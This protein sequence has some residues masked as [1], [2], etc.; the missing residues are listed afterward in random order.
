MIK[1]NFLLVEQL[2][3][4]RARFDFTQGALD[5]RH[6][7]KFV[8]A[9]FAATREVKSLRSPIL[10]GRRPSPIPPI[11]FTKRRPCAAPP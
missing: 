10:T 8:D 2:E 4:R 5:V 3:D 11:H 7:D 9:E 1:S 6:S